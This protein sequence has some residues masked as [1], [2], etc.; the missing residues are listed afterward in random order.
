MARW[1]LLIEMA[2]KM[3]AALAQSTSA[4]EP[5]AR[6]RE[7]A[8][9]TETRKD[10]ELSRCVEL[11]R[12]CCTP[13]LTNSLEPG[14]LP[15]TLA[16]CS[17]AFFCICVCNNNG[18]ES[19]RRTSATERRITS[20][21]THFLLADFLSFSLS[22]PD[23]EIAKF[24]MNW[25]TDSIKFC[26]LST[27]PKVVAVL[28]VLPKLVSGCISLVTGNLTERNHQFL[29][30]ICGPFPRLKRRFLAT[31]LPREFSRD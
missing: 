22:L 23:K 5:A 7:S 1:T 14:K 19:E 9:N 11:L 21:T 4:K 13:T 30:W 20:S 18:R 27:D 29:G 8:N 25:A 10:G 12:H 15:M 3:R 24:S 2:G 31:C 17:G 26:L 6:R 28:P 16:P